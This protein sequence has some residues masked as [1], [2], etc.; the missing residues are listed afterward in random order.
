MCTAACPWR[1]MP[2][3]LCRSH[4]NSLVAMPLV[5]P[6][7]AEKGANV[8][9]AQLVDIKFTELFNSL[10][11]HT[12]DHKVCSFCAMHMCTTAEKTLAVYSL[13]IL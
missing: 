11:H 9:P 8:D 6:T 13:S 1:S 4:K 2:A 5:E 12:A 7:S 3:L 10:N